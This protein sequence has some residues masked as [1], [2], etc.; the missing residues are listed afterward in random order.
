MLKELPGSSPERLRVRVLLF[1]ETGQGTD[2]ATLDA[3]YVELRMP[4]ASIVSVERGDFARWEQLWHGSERGTLRALRNADTLRLYVPMVGGGER[5]A[6][7]IVEV[8]WPAGKE[9]HV[10]VTGRFLF[11]GGRI[12]NPPLQDWTFTSGH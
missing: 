6:S 7:G 10:G 11:P 5:L 4:G 2:L 3:N 12:W 8:R 9:P 1:N